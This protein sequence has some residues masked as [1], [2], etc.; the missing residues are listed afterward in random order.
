MLIPPKSDPLTDVF[1][2]VV[3]CANFDRIIMK[4]NDTAMAKRILTAMLDAMFSD[5]N[6]EEMM[7]DPLFEHNSVFVLEL[8]ARLL[9]SNRV[10]AGELYPIFFPSFRN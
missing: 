3:H 1:H 10:H 6:V 2:K 8:A 5:G 4:T 9:I 7:S